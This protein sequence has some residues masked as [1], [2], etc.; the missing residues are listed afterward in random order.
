MGLLAFVS[1]D[2]LVRFYYLDTDQSYFLSLSDHELGKTFVEDNFSCIDFNPRKRILVVGSTQGKV[3]MWKCNATSSII[4]STA[5]CWEAFCVVDT[6]PGLI[7]I[8]WITYMG[9]LYLQSNKKNNAMLSE[10]ILQ[11]KMNSVMKVIQ[12]SQKTLEI[13]IE[14]D[15]KIDKTCVMTLIIILFILKY[16][17]LSYY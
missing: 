14:K 8:K 11:K 13:I 1:G 3:H 6:I 5:D 7:G 2:D 9:L 15:G 10:T 12:I 4:P 17:L 16:K